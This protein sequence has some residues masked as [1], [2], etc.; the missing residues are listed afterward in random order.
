MNGIEG[1]NNGIT[2]NKSDIS[3]RVKSGFLAAGMIMGGVGIVTVNEA[4]AEIR[5]QGEMP[6]QKGSVLDQ[7]EN[8][9]ANNGVETTADLGIIENEKRPEQITV[10][11]IVGYFNSE[12][13][14]TE[15]AI[16]SS[17]FSSPGEEIIDLGLLNSSDT[18]Q[19]R[20]LGY[21]ET[22][23]KENLLLFVGL[24]DKKQNRFVVPLRLALYLYE[25]EN[26]PHGFIFYKKQVRDLKF[27]G[28]MTKLKDNSKIIQVL[29]SILYKTIGVELIILKS[30]RAPISNDE[31]YLRYVEETQ[32]DGLNISRS[33]AYDLFSNGIKLD[34]SDPKKEV[35]TIKGG[36]NDEIK[37]ILSD[38]AND[39]EKVVNVPI[40]AGISYK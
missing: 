21:Q 17:L 18:I 37:N 11:D 35:F 16:K 30:K 32:K 29:D 6:S 3:R 4:R 10:E 24:K 12:K 36:S 34:Y 14:H 22:E 9:V 2:D 25:N 1:Q 20:F 15:E 28:Q 31:S 19:G 8:R 23:D 26:V 39:N 40:I 5:I 27:D 38:L 33:L 7:I 13:P